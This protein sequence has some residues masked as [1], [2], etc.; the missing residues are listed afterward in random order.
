MVSKELKTIIDM[1]NEQAKQ[2][3][4]K[5]DFF[6]A[7]TEEQIAEFEKSNN[8]AFPSKFRQWL[9]NSDGGECFLPVG[10]QF[11]GVAHKPLID[12]NDNNRPDDSYIIIGGL[13][14]GD[15]ILIKKNVEVVSI[16]NKEEGK[17]EEEEVYDDFF[18]FLNN[19]YDYLGLGE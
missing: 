14:N 1:L 16:Y 8:F 18:T 19:L 7:A 5:M 9:L 15:P 4:S 3:N 13:P 2:S 17:I 6:E 12:V 11:Y 10:A